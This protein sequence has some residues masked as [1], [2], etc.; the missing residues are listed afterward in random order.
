MSTAAPFPPTASSSARMPSPGWMLDVLDCVPSTNP[1]A[2]KML[3][4]HAVRARTQT[5]GRGRTGRHW[6]SDEGGLWLSAVLPCPG[7]RSRWAVL[8]L[9]AGWSVI[10]AL[11]ELGVQNLR[12]RWPNDIMTGHRKLAGLLVERFSADTAVVGLG[13]NIH[14]QPET[15]EP[16]LSRATARLA[17]LV[18]P[19]FA[20]DSD[21]E[22][23]IDVV[24]HRILR[25]LARAQT[26]LATEGFA[27]IAA[28]LNRSW[29][30]PRLVSVTLNRQ[31][32]FTGLF[33][34]ID[35]AGRLIIRTSPDAPAA[36]YDAT[37]VELLRE[38][39]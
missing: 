5:A 15:A 32:P 33:Q 36:A 14:N 25:A 24:A 6:V 23:D 39:E 29:G 4:W 31:S 21:G 16:S 37:Q 30:E 10:H 18:P 26:T 13:L 20:S 2:G 27:P 38:L 17:D 8:P 19:G 12:L 7:E 3:P 11:R 28:E 34:G 22:L 1:I 35:D 9:A